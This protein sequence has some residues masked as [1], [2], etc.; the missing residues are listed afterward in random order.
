MSHWPIACKRFGSQKISFLYQVFK[1]TTLP[2][3]HAGRHTRQVCLHALCLLVKVRQGFC[4]L[5]H[6]QI[7]SLIL[8]SDYSKT[9]CVISVSERITNVPCKISE[10][11]YSMQNVPDNFR[12]GCRFWVVTTQ[13]TKAKTAPCVKTVLYC[14]SKH[15]CCLETPAVCKFVENAYQSTL[16]SCSTRFD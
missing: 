13:K 16:I 8:S 5:T 3:S 10:I 1:P 7:L 6:E 2:K 12:N 11:C 15:N 14:L 4:N 9:D